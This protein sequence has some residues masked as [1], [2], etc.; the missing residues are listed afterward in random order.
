MKKRIL[1]LL[2]IVLSIGMLTGCAFDAR[3]ILNRVNE[4]R[5]GAQ[6]SEADDGHDSMTE[7]DST[8]ADSTGDDSSVALVE[9]DSLEDTEA[10]TQ[11]IA[12]TKEQPEKLFYSTETYN[13]E[14]H[15]YSSGE[16]IVVYS[17]HYERININSEGY[18]S[19]QDALNQH[20]AAAEQGINNNHEDFI[21]YVVEEHASSCDCST[22][23][24]DEQ[25][26][27]IFRADSDFFSV[28]SSCDS[29]MGG[30]HPYL[31]RDSL[32]L[33]SKTGEEIDAKEL[34]SKNPRR[35]CE[36]LTEHMFEEYPGEEK[37]EFWPLI[38]MDV[39]TDE[40]ASMIMTDYLM[41][42]YFGTEDLEKLIF[43]VDDTNKV[44]IGFP[45][46]SLSSYAFG[47]VWVEIPYDELAECINE[48]YQLN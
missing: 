32:F 29:Y 36:I 5:Q 45:A 37:Y 33:D 9:G 21:G 39:E 48:K 16:D 20:F 7:T 34:F 19:L 28:L 18:E 31:S 27:V 30:A 14:D 25:Y 17:R 35:F 47:E 6:S 42:H 43:L 38:D 41:D 4:K 26:Y 24:Y 46:Y 1:S 8:E 40:E 22:S 23:C 15:L 13:Y 44:I 10:T 2:V 12:E 11:E 3:D